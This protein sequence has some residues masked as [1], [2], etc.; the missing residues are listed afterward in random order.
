MGPIESDH[1]GSGEP[2]SGDIRSCDNGDASLTQHTKQ[3]CSLTKSINIDSIVV[4]LQK[5]IF[6]PSVMW[7]PPAC[8]LAGN[9]SSKSLIFI[10][11]VFYYGVLLIMPYLYRFNNT[12]AYGPPRSFDPAQEVVV[13]AGGASGIGSAIARKYISRGVKVALLDIQDF[14]PDLTSILGKNARVYRC[15]ATD[16]SQIEKTAKEIEHDVCRVE[17]FGVHN[18]ETDGAIYSL[19]AQLSLSTLSPQP[20]IL[21]SCWSPHLKLSERRLMPTS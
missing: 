12:I 4:I 9:I 17:L 1:T 6:N 18:T 5:T 3:R 10:L 2:R 7:L 15:D 20:S 11:A 19:E 14:P 8:M 16:L 21:T 13:I